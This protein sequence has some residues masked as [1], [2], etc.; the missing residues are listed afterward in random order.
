MPIRHG[1]LRP[2]LPLID[3]APLFFVAETGEPALTGRCAVVALVD[4]S[5]H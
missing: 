2:G 1:F 3:L 4:I 5:I